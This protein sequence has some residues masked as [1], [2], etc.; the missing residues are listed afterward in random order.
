MVGSIVVVPRHLTDTKINT[1]TVAQA[2]DAGAFLVHDVCLREKTTTATACPTNDGTGTTVVGVQLTM[3]T[4]KFFSQ[5]WS[6]QQGTVPKFTN[7][8]TASEMS[9]VGDCNSTATMAKCALYGKTFG[10]AAA[11]GELNDFWV[12][13]S[14]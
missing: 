1:V 4:A 3:A 7:V 8:E 10:S 9:V 5:V 12:T 2:T 11:A 14:G 13:R 6:T